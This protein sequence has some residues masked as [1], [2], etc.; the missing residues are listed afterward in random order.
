MCEAWQEQAQ[1]QEGTKPRLASKAA[2]VEE[3]GLRERLIAPLAAE[4]SMP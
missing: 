4:A 3:E 1:P 2:E